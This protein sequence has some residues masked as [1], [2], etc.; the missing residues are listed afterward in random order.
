MG[1]VEAGL[2][3]NCVSVSCGPDCR[4]INGGCAALEQ[5]G[6]DYRHRI[7]SI[8]INQLHLLSDVSLVEAKNR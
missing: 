6:V 3:S 5:S 7:Y 1:E 4:L 8:Y 2:E